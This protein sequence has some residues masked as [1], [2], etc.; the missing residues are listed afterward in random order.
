MMT[1]FLYVTC[2]KE[3]LKFPSPKGNHEPGLREEAPHFE[4]NTTVFLSALWCCHPEVQC[5]LAPVAWT[6]VAD[7][8]VWPCPLPHCLRFQCTVWHTHPP[9]VSD[10]CPLTLLSTDGFLFLT[11]WSH[12][13]S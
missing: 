11:G 5:C 7:Q 8:C 3:Q 2:I 6:G 12:S 1:Y 4:K 13:E 9:V 10:L